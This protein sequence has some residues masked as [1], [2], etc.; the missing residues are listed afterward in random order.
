M[1]SMSLSTSSLMLMFMTVDVSVYVVDADVD[2]VAARLENIDLEYRFDG[3]DV[4]E[5]FHLSPEL[6]ERITAEKSDLWIQT[7][8]P[9]LSTA[10]GALVVP[11]GRGPDRW[12][13][14]DENGRAVTPES[15]FNHVGDVELTVRRDVFKL[16]QAVAYDDNDAEKTQKMMRKHAAKRSEKDSKRL[17]NRAK[18]FRKLYV[19]RWAHCFGLF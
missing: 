3:S 6:K 13:R 17:E 9:G 14:L 5:F 8:L 4:E 7:L 2:V 16:P 11:F 10:T 19:F 12:G 15:E 18:M 1:S